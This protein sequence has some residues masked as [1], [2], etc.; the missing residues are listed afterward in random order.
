[1]KVQFYNLHK[2]IYVVKKLV[3]RRRN[4]YCKYTFEYKI[5]RLRDVKEDL[6]RK[7]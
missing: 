5:G 2:Y 3:S 6:K 1:M 7:G 4:V